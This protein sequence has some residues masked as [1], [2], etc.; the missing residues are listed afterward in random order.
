MRLTHNADA[1][2]THNVGREVHQFEGHAWNVR[3]TRAAVNHNH[4]R[5]H[6]CHKRPQPLVCFA[7]PMQ[8]LSRGRVDYNYAP[9]NPFTPT[10]HDAASRF[11]RGLLAT[12]INHVL[13]T[14]QPLT[15]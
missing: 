4:Q 6:C 7:N 15:P 9:E 10:V 13:Q 11:I 1:S 12:S 2:P 14:G 3:T 8:S 5:H